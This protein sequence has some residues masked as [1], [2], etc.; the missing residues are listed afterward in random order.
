M[1]APCRTAA[2]QAERRLVW[3]R[4]EEGR[5]RDGPLWLCWAGAAESFFFSF[6]V[7]FISFTSFATKCRL[8]SSYCF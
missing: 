4:K 6:F 5:K 7:L 3:S 1:G 2:A 8:A